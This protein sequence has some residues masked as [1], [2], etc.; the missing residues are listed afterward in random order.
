MSRRPATTLSGTSISETFHTYGHRWRDDE[1]RTEAAI[2]DAFVSQSSTPRRSMSLPKIQIDWEVD[3]LGGPI[4]IDWPA[5][6]E[7]FISILHEQIRLACGPT[8]IGS[9]SAGGF[10]QHVR[11]YLMYGLTAPDGTQARVLFGRLADGVHAYTVGESPADADEI[12]A[13]SRAVVDAVDQLHK[14]APEHEWHAVIGH[15]PRDLEPAGHALA[16]TV[17]TLTLSEPSV[18]SE[19]LDSASLFSGSMTASLLTGVVGKAQ[20]HGARSALTRA[21]RDLHQLCALVTIATGQA[22]IVR[23][24]AQIQ[25]LPELPRAHAMQDRLEMFHPALEP[26]CE[27]LPDWFHGGWGRLESD[28]DLRNAANAHLEGCQLAARHP[29]YA[30]IA[31]VGAIEGLAVR[32]L[33]EPKHCTKCK[34]QTGYGKLY[35]DAVHLADPNAPRELLQGA[36]TLRSKTAHVGELHGDEASFG[37]MVPPALFD[38]NDPVLFQWTVVR[39]LRRISEEL[40]RRA[41]STGTIKTEAP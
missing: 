28:A 6:G 39:P 40:V 18:F 16:G 20:A 33:G 12:T 11:S 32:E 30:L 15:D 10:P 24:A 13:L 38:L 35:R 37:A 23:N 25:E 34:S 1:E 9:E 5:E 27:S 14:E 19:I 29:S 22:W 21:T 2:D 4:D 26:T 8:A 36:Y 41:L 17:R 7:S 31:F 3:I